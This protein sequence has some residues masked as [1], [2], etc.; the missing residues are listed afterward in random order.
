[1]DLAQTELD[2][3]H[4]LLLDAQ[5]R[6]GDRPGD[7]EMVAALEL[8]LALLRWDGLPPPDLDIQLGLGAAVELKLGPDAMCAYQQ[9]RAERRKRLAAA[10]T[11]TP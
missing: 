3:L 11:L 8:A 9:W 2:F 5:A 6:L 1:M 4:R 10:P 7:A